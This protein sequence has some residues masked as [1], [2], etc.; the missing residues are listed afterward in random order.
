MS[1]VSTGKIESMNAD[2]GSTGVGARV[3]QVDS[4]SVVF[5]GGRVVDSVSLEVARGEVVGLVGA[6]GSGKTTL[7]RT[8]A[9]LSSAESGVVRI[10]GRVA[11]EAGGSDGVEMS[12]G[13][14][15]RM[16]AYMPQLAESHPFTALETVLMG[17]YPHLGRFELEGSGDRELAWLMMLDNYFQ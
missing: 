9:G 17:R 7:V 2:D 6:N 14:R 10:D 12:Q 16:L 1:V 13:D 5:D 3:L 11:S 8:I 15:A 4:L